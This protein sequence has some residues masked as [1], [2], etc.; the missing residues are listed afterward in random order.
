M[1]GPKN[2]MQMANIQY[3]KIELE[4]KKR[5]A[6]LGMNQKNHQNVIVGQSTVKK[7]QIDLNRNATMFLPPQLM[8]KRKLNDENP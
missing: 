7:S 6:E 5:Q 1:K 2:I 3:T 4:N 8:K